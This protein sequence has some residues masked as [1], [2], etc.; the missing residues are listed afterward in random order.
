[1]EHNMEHPKNWPT[2]ADEHNA[3]DTIIE[4]LT[5]LGEDSYV[6]ASLRPGLVAARNNIDFDHMGNPW[7]EYDRKL[8]QK[9][10]AIE[11]MKKELN[12]RALVEDSLKQ[13]IFDAKQTIKLKD[14][15]LDFFRK[16]TTELKARLYDYMIDCEEGE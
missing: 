1:M 4:I 9:S 13:K 6:G 12:T 8:E 7:E 10:E 5:D 15:Q 11:Q 2:K 3:L 14:K 16:K